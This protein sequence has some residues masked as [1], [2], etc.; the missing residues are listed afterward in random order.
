[1]MTLVFLLMTGSFHD[2]RGLLRGMV[3]KVNCKVKKKQK[4]PAWQ[5]YKFLIAERL[6]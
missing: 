2:Y 5:R 3:V 6:F 4:Y 1:M